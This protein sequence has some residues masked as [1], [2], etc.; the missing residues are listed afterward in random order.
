MDSERSI[1][2]R[3]VKKVKQIGG[4]AYKFISPGNKGVPDR[5]VIFPSG[6]IVFT[7]LKRKD[8]KLAAMQ[9]KQKKDLEKL[10]QTVRTVYSKSE[11][12]GLISEFGGAE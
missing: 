10:N 12:D 4:K 11:V 9:N 7:E 1:E 6:K 2:Q 8:G 5:V 3:L